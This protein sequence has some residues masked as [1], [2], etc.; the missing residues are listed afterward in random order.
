VAR[1]VG[2]LSGRRPQLI[3]NS[4]VSD[5]WDREGEN[6]ECFRRYSETIAYPVGINIVFYLM[7]HRGC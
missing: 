4:D 5:G 1:V 2:G 7:T 6:R 3:L